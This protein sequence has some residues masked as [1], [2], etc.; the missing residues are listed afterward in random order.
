M[1][2]VLLFLGNMKTHYFIRIAILTLLFS[3][4]GLCKK[5][6]KHKKVYKS[7]FIVSYTYFFGYLDFVCSL[8]IPKLMRSSEVYTYNIITIYILQ[9]TMS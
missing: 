2:V 1:M 8:L 4:Y 5:K 7:E 3:Q 6:K 9:Y